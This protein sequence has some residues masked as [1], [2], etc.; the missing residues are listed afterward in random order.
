MSIKYPLYEYTKYTIQPKLPGDIINLDYG[1]FCSHNNRSETIIG[2]I[3][4]CS[5]G[6]LTIC[7]NWAYILKRNY[8][9][10]RTRAP[11]LALFH[12]ITFA[13]VFFIPFIAEAMIYSGFVVA[14]FPVPCTM[15]VYLKAFMMTCRSL[16]TT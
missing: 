4:V 9:P 16:T 8:F 13:F 11:Y 14:K 6:I 1:V 12:A 10:I 5:L 3:I 15:L 2:V 7:I